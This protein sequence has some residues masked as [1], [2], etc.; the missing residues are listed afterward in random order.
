MKLK[1]VQKNKELKSAVMTIR[2]TPKIRKWLRDNNISPQKV[3][4]YA[5]VEILK[6]KVK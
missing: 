1:D 2:T 4:D 6:E 5:I 3:F